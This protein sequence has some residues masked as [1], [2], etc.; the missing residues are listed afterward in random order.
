MMT[1]RDLIT[2]GVMPAVGSVGLWILIMAILR[3]RNFRINGENRANWRQ[4]TPELRSHEVEYHN[5]ATYKA[6]EF[7]IKIL[8]A[9]VGGVAFVA[10][11]TEKM[12]ENAKSLVDA[13][14][15]AIVV[16]SGLFCFLMFSHQKAKIERWQRRYH[17]L[18]PLLWN[19][20]WFSA[21]AIA[22]ACVVRLTL[23]PALLK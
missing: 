15:W 13:G 19:E 20:C 22:I 3:A 5:N 2:T 1:H 11:R 21:T 7:Y 18:D 23:T 12:S 9:V 17:L 10:T 8:L 4:L 14:S 16:V 6:F